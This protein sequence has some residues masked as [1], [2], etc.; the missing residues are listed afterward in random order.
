MCECI[1]IL[2]TSIGV[3]LL[4]D[5]PKSC[6]TKVKLTNCAITSNSGKQ[7]LKLDGVGFRL[8]EFGLKSLW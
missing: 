5:T 3:T 4:R 8:S 1:Y 2:T 7:E 6:T